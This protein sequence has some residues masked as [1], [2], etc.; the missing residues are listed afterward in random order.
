MRR[1]SGHAFSVLAHTWRR[2]ESGARDGETVRRSSPRRLRDVVDPES[3]ASSAARARS[4][5]QIAV[6]ISG[7]PPRCLTISSVKRP[8]PTFHAN[9]RCPRVFP[10]LAG[11]RVRR[12][13]DLHGTARLDLSEKRQPSHSRQRVPG[14]L[15]HASSR[16]ITA[17]RGLAIAATRQ[18]TRR[19]GTSR[20]TQVVHR[21]PTIASPTC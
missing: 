3:P 21:Q 5:R 19:P 16:L 15:D 4:R 18:H 9:A 12:R 2:L 20:P 8:M 13:H 11:P 1:R 10:S 17:S 14:T 7:L 6:S